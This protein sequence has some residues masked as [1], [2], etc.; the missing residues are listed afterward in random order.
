MQLVLR[1]LRILRNRD[2]ELFNRLVPPFSSFMLH[3]EVEV[4]LAITHSEDRD[5]GHKR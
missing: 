5:R 1:I 2:G 3:S 4:L